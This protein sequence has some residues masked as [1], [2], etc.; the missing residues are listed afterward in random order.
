MFRTCHEEQGKYVLHLPGLEEI[1]SEG[2]NSV[3]RRWSFLRMNRFHEM[4]CVIHLTPTSNFPFSGSICLL[5][6]LLFP[7]LEDGMGQGSY[8]KILGKGVNTLKMRITQGSL[9]FI[10][11]KT[12]LGS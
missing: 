9:K 3:F 6:L 10:A 8:R 11:D 5:F 12:V 2:E 1:G 4:M 7:F